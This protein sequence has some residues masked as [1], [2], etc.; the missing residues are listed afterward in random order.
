MTW[1]SFVEF[2]IRSFSFFFQLCNTQV[3]F[4]LNKKRYESFLPSIMDKLC[5]FKG[6][7]LI[8]H[9]GDRG[10]INLQSLQAKIVK[11]GSDCSNAKRSTTGL[12]VTG[13]QR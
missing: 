11:I 6:T 10:L 8:W 4:S 9:G 2:F 1:A 12:S 13:P 3:F 7:R 5:Y